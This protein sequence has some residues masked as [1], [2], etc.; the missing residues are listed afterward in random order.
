MSVEFRNIQNTNKEQCAI[1]LE[2]EAQNGFVSHKIDEKVEHVFHEEC[3]TPWLKNNPSC[4]LCRLNVSSIN[5][6]ALLPDPV[7]GRSVIEAARVG[8]HAR[9]R[10]LLSQGVVFEGHGEALY[11]AAEN[12]HI[13]IVRILMENGPISERCRCIALKQAALRG[14]IDI[15]R[16]FL[17]NSPISEEGRGQ[18]LC[19]AA[20][21]GR[22][23]IARILIENGPISEENRGQ[24]LYY[25]AIGGHIDIARIL[26]ENGTISER[27]RRAAVIAANVSGSNEIVQFITG[28][29]RPL[30]RQAIISAIVVTALPALIGAIGMYIHMYSE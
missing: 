1:C 24:A 18:A 16:I 30:K 8:N 26:I 5:G 10:E 20:E 21:G 12:G 11:N 29:N 15:V 28:M 25:A 19:Y 6:Q 13:D 2:E 9:V 22:I 17:E 23:D 14:F 27:D 7:L 4:P 3:L